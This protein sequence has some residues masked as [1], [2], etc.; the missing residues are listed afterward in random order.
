[1]EIWKEVKGFEN[2]EVS[3]LGRV[4]SLARVVLHKNGKVCN[5]KERILKQTKS[6]AG[7]LKVGLYKDAI[8]KTIFAHQLVAI[9]FLNHNPCGMELVVD[10]KSGY[11]TDNTVENLQ[12]I[13]TR[14]NTSKGFKNCSSKH[15]GVTW[16]KWHKKWM[17][18]ITVSKKIIYLGYFTD[19][20]KA[21]EAYQKALAKLVK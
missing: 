13:T 1:M 17:S 14:E 9:A 16:S 5:H 18:Y 3:S 6:V 12:I 4:K 7:Y 2:Y 8:P 10:H 19:E 11:K 21:A 15:V 20:L